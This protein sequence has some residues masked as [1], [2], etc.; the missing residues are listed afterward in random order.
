MFHVECFHM[1]YILAQPLGWVFF[2]EKANYERK[3]RGRTPLISFYPL[4]LVIKN[5]SKAGE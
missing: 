3:K 1:L 5:Q 2:F 4:M